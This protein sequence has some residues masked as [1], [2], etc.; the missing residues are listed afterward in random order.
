MTYKDDGYALRVEYATE[1]LVLSE[2]ERTQFD[3]DLE[4]LADVVADF[5]I[6]ACHVH[7]VRHSRS[8]EVDVK[9]SVQLSRAKTVFTGDKDQSVHPAFKRCVHKLIAKVQAYKSSMGGRPENGAALPE[10]KVT[11]TAAPAMADIE[12]A[13]MRQDYAAFRDAMSV[14]REPLSKRVGRRVERYPEASAL[15]GN[16]LLLSEIVE[17]VFLNAFDRF[18]ERPNPPETLGEWLETLIDPSI[19]E[20][21]DH[22]ETER[23]NLSFL[24]TLRTIEADDR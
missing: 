3:K 24:S 14:Y 2:H 6:A 1:N 18:A 10:K 19:R 12:D 8:H 23:E 21:L 7:I 5:P 15:L 9:V 13:A 11:A 16:E 17:E 22:P 20:L 4:S